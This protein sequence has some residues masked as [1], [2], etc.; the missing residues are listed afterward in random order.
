[1]YL[2]LILVLFG[3][4]LVHLDGSL[5]PSVPH[6]L[7]MYIFLFC[8]RVV[9]QRPLVIKPLIINK[10]FSDTSISPAV[11]TEIERELV[12]RY[13]SL[14]HFYLASMDAA[15]VIGLKHGG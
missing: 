7:L 4:F 12:E 5:P 8:R 14:N 1:M 11:T 9:R 10:R 6:Q 13:N 3:Q 2:Q 15:S